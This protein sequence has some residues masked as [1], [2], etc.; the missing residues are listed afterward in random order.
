MVAGANSSWQLIDLPSP[1]ARI[2]ITPARFVGGVLPVCVCSYVMAVLV[3]V[4]NTRHLRILLLAVALA[5][6]F[7]AATKY[8]LTGGDPSQAFQNF[9]HCL[10]MTSTAMRLTTWAF[11]S[12]PLRRTGNSRSIFL[13]ALDLQC[14]LRGIGW[15]WGIPAKHLPPETRPTHSKSAFLLATVA[16]LIQIVFIYDALNNIARY[17]TPS[18]GSTPSEATIFDPALPPVQRYALSSFVSVLY[19]AVFYHT[20]ELVYYLATIA[21]LMIPGLDQQPSDWPTFSRPPWLATSLADYWGRRWHQSNRHAYV[22]LSYPFVVLFGRAGLILGAFFWSAV[23]HAVGVWGMGLGI[24]F[25][26]TGGFFMLM[27]AGVTLEECYKSFT[28]RK[29]D[30]F[31]GWLWTISFMVVGGNLLVDCWIKTGLFSGE[32][33]PPFAQPVTI[34][35]RYLATAAPLQAT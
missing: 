15:T 10:C 3:L 17:C 34:G 8:D 30:G 2:P 14:N 16:R 4:P 21:A 22:T 19:G 25:T 26:S 1:E 28:G 9:G 33:L 11:I 13:D 20:I 6:T 18:V 32:V 12:E 24:D 23:L 35:L 27:G 29:I 7:N 31:S 5:L